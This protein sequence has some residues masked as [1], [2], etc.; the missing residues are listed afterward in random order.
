MI[1]LILS[2]FILALWAGV[3]WLLHFLWRNRNGFDQ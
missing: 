1:W 3:M 2:P